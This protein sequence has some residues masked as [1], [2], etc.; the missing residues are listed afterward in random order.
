VGARLVYAK[1]IDRQLYLTR[2]GRV[3]PGLENEVVLDEERGVAGAFLVL[4]A[5]TENHGTM[6]EQWRIEAPGGLSIYESVPRELHL[7]TETHVE[8]LED[9]IVDLDVDVAADDYEIVFLLDE[10]EVARARFPVRTS[11][12][13]ATL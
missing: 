4:R 1:V 6:T 5:W 10:I 3:H 13:S 11:E 9:E 8:K 2:G 7:A 12:E